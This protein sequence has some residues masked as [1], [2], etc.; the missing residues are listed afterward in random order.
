MH[1]EACRKR[2]EGAMEDPKAVKRVK[3]CHDSFDE[4]LGKVL[5][6][7]MVEEGRVDL[8]HDQDDS[9]ND[10][11]VGIPCKD[12]IGNMRHVALQD[13]WGPEAIK[14]GLFRARRVP[15]EWNIRDM[16]T[17]PPERR[18]IE[19]NLARIGFESTSCTG[20]HGSPSNEVAWDWSE[21]ACR[22]HPFYACIDQLVNLTW[23]VH[24][25]WRL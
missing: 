10:V 18:S 12:E 7:S 3:R 20:S 15:T 2:I 8:T 13:L 11:M 21:G 14:R 19:G 24:W 9:H 5:E 25:Y 22:K 16:G 23:H 1:T 4:A 6:E 17:K